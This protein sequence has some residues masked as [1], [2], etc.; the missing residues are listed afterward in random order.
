M[1]QGWWLMFCSSFMD[2]KSLVRFCS[3]L[4]DIA[5]TNG[6]G[7]LTF[8]EWRDSTARTKCE[9]E[10]DLT[11]YEQWAKFDPANVGY[12]TKNEAISIKA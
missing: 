3:L 8:M 1:N 5:D 11:L 7:K 2:Q 4:F 6:D 9:H 10:S 12:V